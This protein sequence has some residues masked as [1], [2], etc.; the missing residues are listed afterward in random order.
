MTTEHPGTQA[1]PGMCGPAARDK[2]YDNVKH[3]RNL[4]SPSAVQE[5]MAK[6]GDTIVSRQ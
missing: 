1:G 5:G 3:E 6:T 2:K 4:Q